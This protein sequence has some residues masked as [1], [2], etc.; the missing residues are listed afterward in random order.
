MK[1][2]QFIYLVYWDSFAQD[3]YLYGS[4]VYFEENRY[5]HYENEMMPP[6]TVIKKWYSEVNYQAKRVEPQLPVLEVGETYEFR[7]FL[8]V[9]P[10]KGVKLRVRFYNQ[11]NEEM[12]VQ[13]LEEK[14]EKVFVPPR[15]YRYELELI[16]TGARRMDFHHI[17]I[18]KST[19]AKKNRRKEGG[20]HLNVLALE[21]KGRCCEIPDSKLL[22]RFGNLY[23]TTA[24]ALEAFELGDGKLDSLVDDLPEGSVRV[25]GYGDVSDR[26]AYQY[27]RYVGKDTRAYVYRDGGFIQGRHLVIY[28]KKETE[29][30]KTQ[31]WESLISPDERL[32][33]VVM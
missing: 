6:G 13:I 12:G 1:E 17:E 5:V 19:E 8:N 25:I 26:A 9:T 2:K 29:A 14:V 16:H 20:E 32:A 18:Q 28:G 15:T 11:Q 21:P 24:D 33:E 23:I 27:A 4:T 7:S 30:S 10:D 22:K 31:L 3:T